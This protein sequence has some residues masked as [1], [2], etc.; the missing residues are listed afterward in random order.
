MPPSGASCGD[1]RE[2]A[3]GAAAPPARAA[4]ILHP[5]AEQIADRKR[6]LDGLD[7]GHARDR[8]GNLAADLDAVG[9]G[10]RAAGAGEGLGQ[11]ADRDCRRA[12]CGRT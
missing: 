4:R 6:R 9:E 10:A 3:A 7:I 5:P 1:D 2:L 11:D 8:V 12:G